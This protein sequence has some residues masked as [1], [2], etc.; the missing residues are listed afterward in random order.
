M[1]G[2][3]A[4]AT[5]PSQCFFIEQSIEQYYLPESNAIVVSIVV[6]LEHA[7]PV[8]AC[9]FDAKTPLIEPLPQDYFCDR[10]SLVVWAQKN[11][12]ACLCLVQPLTLSPIHI[13]KPWGEEVWFTGIE[14]R[15]QSKVLDQNGVAIPLPWLLEVFPKR[16]AGRY[17]RD[18]ILLKILAPLPEPVYGDLYF[19]MHETKREVY[20]VTNV[21]PAAWPDAVGGIRFGFNQAKRAQFVNDDEFRAAYLLAVKSYEQV[22]RTIDEIFDGF[23]VELGV[24]LNAPVSASTNKE[25]VARLPEALNHLEFLRRQELD[26]YAA[27]KKLAV[28]DVVKVPC[29]T[30]HS[31]MH[32]VTTVEFQTPV[33]ERKILSFAQKVLTQSHW[34]TES[35]LLDINIDAP[36]DIALP[37]LYHAEGILREEVVRFDDFAVERITLSPCNSLC[38]DLGVEYALVMAIRGGMTLGAFDLLPIMQARLLPAAVSEIEVANVGSSDLVFLYAYPLSAVHE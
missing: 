6:W 18:I 21:D 23:R 15:G 17:S 19:E 31:L 13:P 25:W 11:S 38:L 12:I 34:D 36:L 5:L 9:L 27:V 24:A 1:L 28:G 20:V 33:Y 7:Q 14:A 26:S 32:G 30:P 22:R 8:W 16:L 3:V 2:L 37:I 35:A 4:D 29:F 10:D